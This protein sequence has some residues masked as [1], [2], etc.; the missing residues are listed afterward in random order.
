MY[1]KLNESNNH[2]SFFKLVKSCFKAAYTSMPP[3]HLSDGNIL[4]DDTSK[5][6]AFNKFFSE[7]S[8]LTVGDTSLPDDD[9]PVC[10]T[11]ETIIVS[12]EEVYNQIRALDANKS[13]GPDGISPK[14]IKLADNT[15]VKPLTKLYNLSLSSGQV[16]MLW[17]KANVV[18]LHKK[19]SKHNR[20]NYRP[21]SLLSILGKILE[22][23][24]FKHV[25]NHFK[26]NFLISMWQ[27]GF[28]PGSSTVTQLIELY[29]TFCTA[30]S[31]NKEIRIVFLDISKAFDRVWHQG[32]LFKLKKMWYMWFFASVV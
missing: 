28:L 1:D 32:L 29:N 4:T 2:C 21:V 8:K 22:R 24:V 20:S 5:A 30:V 11:L 13:Y 12:E 9:S 14:F 17:K 6:N 25:Y 16:P 10:N 7:A 15:L 31:S 3:I 18:P 19:D 26:D 27:S 23:I